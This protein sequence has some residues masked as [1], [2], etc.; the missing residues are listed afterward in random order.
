MAVSRRLAPSPWVLERRSCRWPHTNSRRERGN[1]PKR[2]GAMAATASRKGKVN[3]ARV[4]T[5]A[6]PSQVNREAAVQPRSAARPTTPRMRV[7]RVSAL[8]L[9]DREERSVVEVMAQPPSLRTIRTFLEVAESRR[10]LPHRFLRMALES[11]HHDLPR[12][13]FSDQQC[14]R[15]RSVTAGR[16]EPSSRVTG[17]TG[18]WKANEWHGPPGAIWNISEI[19]NSLEAM[20]RRRRAGGRANEVR[21]GESVV[22]S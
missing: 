4:S 18:E 13:R 5:S 7:H 19:Q 1:H 20:R 6:L 12:S 16:D 9:G 2:P 3:E 21:S 11:S 15:G 17:S 8:V 14:V 10:R 22:R